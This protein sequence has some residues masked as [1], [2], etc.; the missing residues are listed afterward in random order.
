MID[1]T[2][3]PDFVRKFIL[4]YFFEEKQNLRFDVWVVPLSWSSENTHWGVCVCVK[5]ALSHT[6]FFTSFFLVSTTCL[7]LPVPSHLC[8]VSF[9][10]SLHPLHL[11]FPLSELLP[12]HHVVSLSLFLS[13]LRNNSSVQCL[14]RL[15]LKSDWYRVNKYFI[16]GF[17]PN[18]VAAWKSKRLK[19]S[20]IS[21]AETP[22]FS[23]FMLI[24][25]RSDQWEV[26]QSAFSFWKPCRKE[27]EAFPLL[28]SAL[29]QTELL[30]KSLF[31]WRIK[32]LMDFWDESRSR[33]ERMFES[34]MNLWYE[35][36]WHWN[37]K[38][39]DASPHN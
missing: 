5:Y 8:S 12:H 28:L 11:S 27:S 13:L 4:D 36:M 29:K 20:L 3:N 18:L 23:P 15:T 19:R 30:K 9:H 2:L 7:S 31:V 25:K 24:L 1:N 14:D 37:S 26:Q 34:F 6:H 33:T 16:H 38:A 35:L 39:G 21:P 22:L 17:I 32:S 10:S